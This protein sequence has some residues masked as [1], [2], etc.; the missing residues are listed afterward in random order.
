MIRTKICDM[1]EIEYPIIQAAMG[2]FDTKELAAAVATA[3]GFGM[4]SH[5]APAPEYGILAIIADEETRIKAFNDVKNRMMGA[6]REVGR[7]AKGS[8]GVNFRVAPEQPD[9]PMLLDALIEERE[10]DPNLQK[11][12]KMVLCSAGDPTQPHLK[13]IQEA[14]MLRFQTVPSVYHAKKAEK[15]GVDGLIVTGYEAGGH[16]AYEPYHTFVV[17][18]EVVQQVNVPVVGGGGVCDGK[19]LVAMLAFGAQGIYMGTRFIVTK[20]CEF[21][22]KVKQ[23]IIDSSKKYPKEATTIVTQGVYGPLRHLKNKYSLRLYE[24]TQ[25]LKNEEITMQDVWAFESEGTYRAKGPEGN[26]EDGAIWAGQVSL[27]IHKLMTCKEVID[28]IMQE[29]EAILKDLAKK[30][31]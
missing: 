12:L 17:V 15:S 28:S 22:D 6:V 19:G 16:V 1:L 2:P 10:K 21:N 11:K 25:M 3:G 26:I 5:P 13:K 29:A 27:R 18:P 24:L 20:E 9:V 23:A 8:F 4:V 14:G 7:K 31:T 30:Y